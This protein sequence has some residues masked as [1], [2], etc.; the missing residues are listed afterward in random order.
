MLPGAALASAPG[1][2]WWQAMLFASLA[3]GLGWGIR[4]Q[5]GHETGAMI[6]GL[7]VSLV[8]AR[9][10]CPHA[11][12]AA[13][14][15]AV[16]WGTIAIGFG[17]SMTYAQTI[18]LSHDQPLVGNWAALRWGMLGLAIKGGIWIG[19]AGAFLGM[20]LGGKSYSARG[21][22][23]AWLGIL[24]LVALGIWLI[25]EPFDPAHHV[26]PRIYFSD[27][28]HWEPGATLKPRREVWGGMLFGLIGLLAFVRLKARDALAFRLGLW[29]FAGGAVGFP[30]GQ[31]L[32]AYHAWNV[33]YFHSGAWAGLDPIINWWNFMETTFGLV[34]GAALGLGLWLNRKA[35]KVRPRG[36]VIE[37]PAGG[38]VL[39]LVLHVGLLVTSEFFG[40]RWVDRL[41]DF[42]MLLGFIPLVA[43]A[44]GRWWPYVLM[45]PVTALPILGKTIRLV[46][47]EERSVGP[48][49][50]WIGYGLGPLIVVTIL[51]IRHARAERR[52]QTAE[53]FLRPFLLVATWLFFG[54][55]FAFFRFPWPWSPWTYRTP[56]GIVFAICS[57]GLTYCALGRVG[58]PVAM[59]LGQPA[60][61]DQ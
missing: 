30:L 42:G 57:L 39:L 43:V 13:V 60:A 21:M 37:I 45:L 52:S 24:G 8:L 54:L 61:G 19:Y 17:G 49:A 11:E 12:A 44:G 34:L 27:D 55:N 32:Q 6:A 3:G 4:G 36:N 14:A 9:L 26:L 2:A 1:V 18:G 51:A 33:A 50:G 15:R 16:A 58:K 22:V 28:W 23:L 46:V 7:L 56:N 48:V 29:A 59:R 47:Y 41:Y 10:F 25:N 38:E 35:I 53:A 31:C 5:Y 40:V 20:G